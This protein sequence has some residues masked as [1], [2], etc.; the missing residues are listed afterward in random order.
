MKLKDS[1]SGNPN[2]S[3]PYNVTLLV[4]PC[5]PCV[6]SFIRVYQ[7]SLQSGLISSV[8]PGISGHNWTSLSKP[9]EYALRYVFL[10]MSSL[11]YPGPC[12]PWHYTLV[13]DVRWHTVCLKTKKCKWKNSNSLSK[14]SLTLTNPVIRLR[15]D[16]GISESHRWLYQTQETRGDCW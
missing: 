16:W 6:R 5:I 7:H 15:K 8:S 13:L 4:S 14:P 11:S 1:P 10:G 3:L 12:P 2:L 9:S